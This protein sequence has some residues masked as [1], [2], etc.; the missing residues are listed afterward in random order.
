MS[1]SVNPNGV[2]QSVVVAGG[3]TAGWMAAA[4]LS[5][6]LGP[7]GVSITLVESEEIGTVGV[8]EATIP[9]LLNFN[10]LLE[11]DEDDF[12][13]ATEATYKLGI[14][15]VDWRALGDRYFHPFGSYGQALLGVDF[16]HLWLKGRLLGQTAPLDDY[17]LAAVAARQGRFLRPQPQM[18]RSPLSKL[19]Y[20]FHFDA[21]LYARHLR[22]YAERRGVARAEGRIVQVD[23]RAEGL[24]EA[25]VLADGRRVAGDLFI[26][27]TGF[28]GLLIGREM[29]SAYVDWTPWLP[30]DRAVAQPSASVGPPT[31]YTRSTAL[32]AGW[33]WRIPL[34]HRVGN[35][36]VYSSAHLSD[37]E[38]AA[39]LTAGLDGEALAEPRLLRFTAGHRAQPW[40]GNVVSLGLASGFLEPLE[41]TSIHM[42]QTGI[43]RLMTL[44][45]SARFEAAEIAEYNRQTIREYETVRDFL[46]LHYKLT[47]RDDTAFWRACRALPPPEGL[48]RKLE[49]FQSNGRIVREADELFTETSWLAVMVGQGCQARGYHPVV[50]TLDAEETLR[51]LADVREVNQR[52]ASLMPDHLEFL[53]GRRAP[54]AA[55]A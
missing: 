39:V 46:V 41:S 7:Q 38:A 43:A 13:R 19:S 3:G 12:V 16:Q 2:V 21:A 20:A 35:G 47:E 52:A 48:A 11:L 49:L 53:R 6:I 9:Q 51:R 44:F 31:P 50:D 26:D 24:V 15:F 40:I 4:A 36:Y 8:G 45:P 37:D 10:A 32:A 14:E 28:Q 29:G 18:Q 27:C 55:F 5:K 1:D 17:A 42:V 34:Q 22:L 30:C 33:R 54:Q 25:V 23:R